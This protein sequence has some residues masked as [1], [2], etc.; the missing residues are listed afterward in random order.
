ML[1]AG[2][3]H[4]SWHSIVKSGD[5][6]IT[7]LAGM[8]LVAATTVV[9]AVPFVPFPSTSVWA[10]IA[11]SV[12]LH[13]GYKICL[14]R[15]YEVGDL[16]QAFP[17]ARGMVPLFATLF[18]L[19]TLGQIPNLSQW[20]GVGLVSAGIIALALDRIE[21][22]THWS[23]I[24][25]ATGAGMTVAGYS[26]F[27]AYGT[28]LMGDWVAF[29]VWLVIL[30]SLIFLAVA[31]VLRGNKLWIEL[32]ATKARILVSGLLGLASF[33]VFLWALSRNPVGAVSALRETSVLFAGVI[34]FFLHREKLN[35]RRGVG[36]LLVVVGIIIIAL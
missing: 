26:V 31:A 24:A 9:V 27:D 20:C 10:I 22:R 29:T 14:S 21:G 4:A 7:T 2:L 36:A 19:S 1:L 12:G 6:Q 11:L 15:A 32:L 13:V 16:G 28:R 25:A 33:F 35:P 5:S 23:L 17:L 34:G 18:A 3:L 30:D 8:G